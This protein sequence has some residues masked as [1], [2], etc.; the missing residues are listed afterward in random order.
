MEFSILNVFIKDRRE[1]REEGRGGRKGGRGRV[2]PRKEAK[3]KARGER[4]LTGSTQFN[5]AETRQFR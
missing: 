4:V 1:G 2:W 5:K 3:D